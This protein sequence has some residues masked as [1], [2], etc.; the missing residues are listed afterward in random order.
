MENKVQ[1]DG[2]WLLKNDN[3]KKIFLLLN[4]AET[5]LIVCRK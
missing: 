1:M 3:K 4:S 5:Q 2:V